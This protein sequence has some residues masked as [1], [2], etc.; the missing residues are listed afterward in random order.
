MSVCRS[1][2]YLFFLDESDPLTAFPTTDEIK[3]LG[4]WLSNSL[5]PSKMCQHSVR[6]ATKTFYFIRRQFH[7][8]DCRTF[9]L[10][11]P[12]LIRPHLEYCAQI[13]IPYLKQDMEAL[14]KVQRRSTKLISSLKSLPYEERLT[15]LN[16]FPLHYRRIRG[17]LILMFKLH[18]KNEL[19][20][21]FTPSPHNHLRGHPLKLFIPRCNSRVRQFSFQVYPISTWNSLPAEI[22]S[23]QTIPSFKRRLDS[24]LPDILNLPVLVS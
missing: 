23:C 12:T 2:P 17:L 5:N 10:I 1:S 19:T 13:W 4:V 20:L 9:R 21:Y 24:V 16:L 3:D 6:K 18:L 15:R 22:F 8:F 14:E 7:Y 11:Y